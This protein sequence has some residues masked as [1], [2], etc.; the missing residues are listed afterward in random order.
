MNTQQCIK[1]TAL[2]LSNVW[3]LTAMLATVSRLAVD[4]PGAKEASRLPSG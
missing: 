2:E 4:R 3:I 1:T